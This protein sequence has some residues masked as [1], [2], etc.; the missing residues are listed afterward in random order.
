MAVFTTEQFLPVSFK[1]VDGRGRPAA[2]DGEPV[3]ASS[4]E[5]VARVAAEG[6]V[7]DEA[8]TYNMK[9]ESVAPGTARISVTADA[10]V[11]DQASEV[12]G[13]LDVTVELDPRSA[14]RIIELTPGT[15]EDEA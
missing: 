4:D 15:P 8:G 12:V 1:I 7:G 6:A 10:D 5:T 11:S 2:V 9:I 13:Y 14:V 3:V